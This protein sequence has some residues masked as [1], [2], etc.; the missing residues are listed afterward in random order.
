MRVSLPSGSERQPGHLWAGQQQVLM[1]PIQFSR[2]VIK[3]GAPKTGRAEDALR[4]D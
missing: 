2:R 4:R 3:N 1:L